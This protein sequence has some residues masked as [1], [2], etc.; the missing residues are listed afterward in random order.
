MATRTASLARRNDGDVILV[1]W[2]GLTTAAD[3]G[4]PVELKEHTEINV[5]L[6]GTVGTTPNVIIEGSNDLANWCTLKDVHGTALGSLATITALHQVAE[7]PLYIRCRLSATAGG[8]DLD[9]L[10]LMRRPAK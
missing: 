2:E 6:A 10:M 7:K 5:Q 3:V 4:S 9:V 8:T 1:T